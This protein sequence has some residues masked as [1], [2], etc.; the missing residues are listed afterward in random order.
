MDI[1]YI[2]NDATDAINCMVDAEENMEL[3][4]EGGMVDDP[5]DKYH[6]NCYDMCNISTYLIGSQLELMCEPD[7]LL[8][9]EGVFGMMGNH[10]W[11]EVEGIIIDAA[12]CQFIPD[13]NKLSL[14]DSVWDEYY[15]VKS[16][17]FDDWKE[18]SC[19]VGG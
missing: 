7:Q 13:A 15:A 10:T 6:E 16:Y 5:S 11:L 12:L 4:I 17:T 9:K 18:N 1:P 8:V 19:N 2:N 14:V 3:F